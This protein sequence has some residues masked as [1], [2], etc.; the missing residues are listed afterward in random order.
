M[1]AKT[2]SPQQ[3]AATGIALARKAVSAM[4]T[5]NN[6]QNVTYPDVTTWGSWI[7]YIT[8]N[9]LLNPWMDNMLDSIFMSFATTPYFDNRLKKFY[10][11]MI[12]N[13]AGIKQIYI[14]KLDAYP[15]EIGGDAAKEELK[16]YLSDVYEARYVINTSL[17]YRRTLSRLMFRSYLATPEGII[18]FI[19]ALKSMMYTSKE[20]DEFDLTIYTLTR[21]IVQG[22]CYLEPVDMTNGLVEM[23]DFA[24]RYRKISFDL[25]SETSRDYNELGVTAITPRE[26]QVLFITSEYAAQY[27]TEE[28]ASAFNIAYKDFNTRV[29]VVKSFNRDAKKIEALHNACSNIPLPLTGEKTILDDV[30]AVLIDEDLL[31]IYRYVDEMWEKERASRMD[32]N[33]FLSMEK[34]F[35][36]SPFANI[37]VFVKS[38]A[39]TEQPESIEYKV[40]SKAM[41]NGWVTLQLAKDDGNASLVGGGMNLVPSESEDTLVFK[42]GIVKLNSTGAGAVINGR[43]RDVE[44]ATSEAVAPTV[45]VGDTVTFTKKS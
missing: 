25:A 32:I 20:I 6:G 35:N 5:A 27:E 24:T 9:N 40:V 23:S 10:K 19:D 37:V 8:A 12:A 29:E 15:F 7:D 1:A 17:Q 43:I 26:K 36:T 41:A 11:G 4:N 13:G 14:D 42:N 2:L 39:V 28:L 33:Y 31:Q 34:A 3:R 21:K 22:M 45:N 44:Y 38:S 18:D 16:T 30:V